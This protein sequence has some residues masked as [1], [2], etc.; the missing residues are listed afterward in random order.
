MFQQAKNAQ[1]FSNE[2][3]IFGNLPFH[4]VDFTGGVS[5]AE[6]AR[7]FGPQITHSNVPKNPPLQRAAE[8]KPST[9]NFQPQKSNVRQN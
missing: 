5:V 9:R 7:L 1:V 3:R 6:R 8:N 2:E 4:L